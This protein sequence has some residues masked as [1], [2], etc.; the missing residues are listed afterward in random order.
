MLHFSEIDASI[1]KD[2]HQRLDFD[3]LMLPTHILFDIY[4]FYFCYYTYDYI[5]IC[6]VLVL[7]IMCGLIGL[8]FT[9]LD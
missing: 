4:K 6:I 2:F 7:Y 9:L 1:L 3:F 5:S 8:D